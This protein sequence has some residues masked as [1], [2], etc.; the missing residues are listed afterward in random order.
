M[1]IEQIA[2]RNYGQYGVTA[3]LWLKEPKY[4]AEFEFNS[5]CTYKKLSDNL[6]KYNLI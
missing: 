6:S 3:L 5:Y 2:I 1:N 4:D